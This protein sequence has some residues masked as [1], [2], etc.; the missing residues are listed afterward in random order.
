MARG[1]SARLAITDKEKSELEQKGVFLMEDQRK[2]TWGDSEAERLM[3]ALLKY[4]RG[5]AAGR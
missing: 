4:A 2:G 3:K 1:A 5:S